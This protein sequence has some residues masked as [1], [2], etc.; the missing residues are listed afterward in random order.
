[1]KNGWDAFLQWCT[2]LKTSKDFDRFFQL[3]L[4][5]E[6]Q[7][8]IGKRCLIIEALEEGKL[9]QREIAETFGVSIAQ[10]TRGSNALKVIDPGLRKFLSKSKHKKPQR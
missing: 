10:I 2:K 7:E 8:T 9:T 5:L 6:E 3:L 4:T 1:M